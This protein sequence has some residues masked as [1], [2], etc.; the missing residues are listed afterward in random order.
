MSITFTSGG[1]LGETDVSPNIKGAA[2]GSGNS[3][4][5]NFSDVLTTATDENH[6]LRLDSSS[7]NEKRPDGLGDSQPLN[8]KFVAEGAGVLPFSN[9]GV[10]FASNVSPF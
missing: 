5:A 3:P 9:D 1:N 2:K 7:K 6:D 8:K 10:I 4:F